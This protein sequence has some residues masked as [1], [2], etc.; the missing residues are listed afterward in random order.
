MTAVSQLV[1]HFLDIKEND[2]PLGLEGLGRVVAD[3]SCG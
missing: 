3:G 1:P 2:I